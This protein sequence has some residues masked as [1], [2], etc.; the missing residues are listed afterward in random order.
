M[1]V[2]DGNGYNSRFPVITKFSVRKSRIYISR[3]WNAQYAWQI[4]G[5]RIGEMQFRSSYA[6]PFE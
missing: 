2:P 6:A 4:E 3:L 1:A 5:M